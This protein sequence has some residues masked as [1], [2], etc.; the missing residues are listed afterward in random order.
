MAY[1]CHNLICIN[2]TGNK[3]KT[4]CSF[5]QLRSTV[6]DRVPS[7]CHSNEPRPRSGAVCLPVWI[8]AL[9]CCSVNEAMVHHVCTDNT[10]ADLWSADGHRCVPAEQV[11]TGSR[12][13]HHQ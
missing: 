10:A 7:Q 13:I 1:F 2:F 12:G 8:G 9:W 5:K 6:C 4:T 11:G 3:T